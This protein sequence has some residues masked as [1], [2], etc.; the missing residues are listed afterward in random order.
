MGTVWR[1]EDELLGRHVAVKRLHVRPH[2]AD[3]ELATL[4]ER[5]RREARAAARIS[6]RHVVGV[7]DVVEDAGLPCVVMEYVRSRTL[8]EVLKEDGLLRPR[9]AARIGLGMVAALRAAHAAGVL[10]RDVKPGNV[11]LGEDDRIVLTDFGIA[12]ASGTSTLTRT[13]E[14]IGSIDYIAPERVR[15][16]SPGPASDLWA[17]GATLYQAV[18]GRPPFR[19]DT[20]IETAYSIA[21]DPLEPPRNAGALAPLIERLLAKDPADRPAAGEAERLLRRAAAGPGPDDA[22]TLTTAMAGV[23]ED[24][25]G[26]AGET[27]G[28]GEP[29]E[30][31]ATVAAAAGSG[32]GADVDVGAGPGAT[33]RATAATTVATGSPTAFGDSTT[34]RAPRAAAAAPGADPA[35]PPG[36]NPDPGTRAG[37]NSGANPAADFGAGDATPPAGGPAAPPSDRRSRARRL[38]LWAASVVVVAALAVGATV[39]VLDGRIAGPAGDARTAAAQEDEPATADAPASTPP[40]PPKGYHLALEQELGVSVPVPDGWKRK[41]SSATEIDYIDP[42]GLVNL[43][44]NV[45]D[46]AGADP[47]AHWESLEPQTRSQVTGYKRERMQRTTFRG[48]PAAVWEFTF[49][50]TARG[51]RAIDLGFGREGEKEYALYLSAPEDRWDQYKKVFDQARDGLRLP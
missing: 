42:T 45:L 39:V 26:E 25:A 18:E 44:I 30:A 36:A 7:Y 34:T 38:G 23:P 24:G 9:E 10:H 4:H 17:L 50:G 51:Y 32:T 20:A 8:A 28:A 15:G 35:P 46:F 27:G 22:E 47:L 33:G 40:L 5:T 16:G 48:I 1:A 43:K 13:G 6:H 41:R 2:L 29:S 14:L 37:V 31:T 19:K 11:L 3:D 12:Q 49:K 21:V